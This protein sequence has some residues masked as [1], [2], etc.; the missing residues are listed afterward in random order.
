MLLKNMQDFP[1][2]ERGARFRCVIAIA[3]PQGAK[4]PL[5]PLYE[6]GEIGRASCRERV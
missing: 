5:I 4:S 3:E 1:W 6:R 2:E